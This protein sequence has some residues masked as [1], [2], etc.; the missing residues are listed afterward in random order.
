MQGIKT[1]PKMFFVYVRNTFRSKKKSNRVF[2]LNEVFTDYADE[3]A[4][5]LSRFFA[6][7]FRPND[8][9]HS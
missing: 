6:L 9:H 2:K 1:D 3:S 8:H 4:G 7:V 5:A